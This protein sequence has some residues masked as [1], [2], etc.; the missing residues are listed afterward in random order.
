MFSWVAKIGPT[1]L[2]KVASVYIFF[3]LDGD[4]FYLFLPQPVPLQC[5][6]I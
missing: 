6:E 2:P 5:G 1:A 3:I 4:T